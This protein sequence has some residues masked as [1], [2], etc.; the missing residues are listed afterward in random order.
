MTEQQDTAFNKEHF[1][2]IY[3]V[4]VERHYWNRC[5]YQVIADVL[6]S[7]GAKGPVLEIGCGKG[8]VV[9]DLRGRGIDA[10]GVE[11]AVVDALD[12][13]KDH[14]TTGADAMMMDDGFAATVRTILLL[15][16]IEHIEDPKGFLSAIRI[17]FPAARHVICTV[18]ARQ[19]L[20]SNFDR[21][22][23]HFRRYDLATLQAHMDPEGVRT[24]SGGYFF[25]AL[26]P[27][28]ALQL[29]L[30][31]ARRPYFSVPAKGPS[32]W[33]HAML[34]ALFH[35]EYKLLPATW[36]GTSIIA[37]SEER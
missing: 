32:S 14:V 21:F 30:S 36:R 9:A 16:V 1:E 27:A 6:R 7:S 35:L 17:K 31:G 11:L 10:T 19:E 4:G 26:Y 8:L 13:M 33:I 23:G 20:F 29:R 22:N 5:R 25:H 24:W 12:D 2:A 34:G 3:P 15:D 28:A 18:P 37:V